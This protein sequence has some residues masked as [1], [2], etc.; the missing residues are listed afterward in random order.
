MGYR[1]EIYIKAKV[2]H[3]QALQATLRK[4]ELDDC[5]ELTQDGTYVYAYADYL[6]WYDSYEEVQIVNSFINSLNDEAALIAVG[7]DGLVETHG[8]PWELG[9]YTQTVVEG[10]YKGDPVPSN[11]FKY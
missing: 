4:A 2:K 1:S 8:D 7:E 11:P 10:F 9:M 3:T 6:K 5:F